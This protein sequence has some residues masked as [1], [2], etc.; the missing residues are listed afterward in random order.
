M[1][2]DQDPQSKGSQLA[3]NMD[4]TQVEVRKSFQMNGCTVQSRQGRYL[5]PYWD[6]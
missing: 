6:A 4:T 1:T 3:R 2:E 5:T